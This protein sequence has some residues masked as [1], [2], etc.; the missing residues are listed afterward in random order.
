[1]PQ[2]TNKVS[3]ATYT[4]TNE[5]LKR[6]RRS[7]LANAYTF[8][9]ETVKTPPEVAALQH[10]PEGHLELPTETKQAPIT[11]KTSPKRKQS[12]KKGS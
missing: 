5:E 11:N 9:E 1:M 2:I 12:R 10:Q 3:G 4:V 7:S 8:P 6:I